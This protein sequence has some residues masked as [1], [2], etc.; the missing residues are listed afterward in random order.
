M[1]ESSTSQVSTF[2]GRLRVHAQNSLWKMGE[3]ERNNLFKEALRG[4]R[5]IE[6]PGQ[7]S[8]VLSF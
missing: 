3:V 2:R 6:L 1:P 8:R 7:T 4:S 5:D